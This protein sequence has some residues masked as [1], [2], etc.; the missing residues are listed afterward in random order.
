ML[1]KL[2]SP[3]NITESC[4]TMGFETI[5]YTPHHASG[6]INLLILTRL[7]S[8]LDGP[9]LLSIKIAGGYNR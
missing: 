5:S 8:L 2:T 4:E 9:T 1:P 7:D 3:P 6:W